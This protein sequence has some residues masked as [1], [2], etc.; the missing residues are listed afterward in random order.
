MKKIFSLICFIYCSTAFGQSYSS[1]ISDSEIVKFINWKLVNDWTWDEFKLKGRGRQLYFKIQ[2]L[3]TATFYPEMSKTR[4]GFGGVLFREGMGNKILDSLFSKEDRRFLF[5]QFNSQRD[6]VWKDEFSKTDIVYSLKK[7]KKPNRY[8]LSLPLFSINRQYIILEE[9]HYAGPGL[10]G[11][12]FKI[13]KR[14]S[15]NTWEFITV[16]NGWQS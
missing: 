4:V 11:G 12:G 8:Y 14:K 16:L 6:T 7:E 15:D 5:E 9:M 3:D 2:K 1:L 13:Y 10:L